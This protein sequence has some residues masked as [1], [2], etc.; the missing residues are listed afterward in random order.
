MTTYGNKFLW[1]CYINLDNCQTHTWIRS[2]NDSISVSYKNQYSTRIVTGRIIRYGSS[3]YN[4]I[5]LILQTPYF[6]HMFFF[7]KLY[8]ILGD[9]IWSYQWLSKN[10]LKFKVI[11]FFHDIKL[12][13][14]LQV[15]I[16]CICHPMYRVMTKL[17]KYKLHHS[18]IYVAEVVTSLPQNEL[19]CHSLSNCLVL[20]D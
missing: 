5:D 18:H 20:M 3:S 7:M 8:L 4:L 12:E 13:L 9:I 6:F 10:H 19:I 2:D 14:L 15:Q 11:K 17:S 1:P 16:I